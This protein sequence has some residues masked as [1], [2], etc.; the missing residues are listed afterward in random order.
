MRIGKVIITVLVLLSFS[1]LGLA[2]TNQE[3]LELLEEKFLKGE[4]SETNYDRLRKKYEGADTT[5][6]EVTSALPSTS[7]ILSEGFEGGVSREGIPKGWARYYQ[8]GV[9][10]DNK[11]CYR[12]K[13]SLKLDPAGGK[14]GGIQRNV[15]IE[16]GK[17]Y[18]LRVWCY[19]EGK[20][21][22]MMA[23][24]CPGLGWGDKGLDI[25]IS[26]G[27][28]KEF[29]RIV[30]VPVGV[31]KAAL[32]FA[33]WNS[34][35][36]LWV[37]DISVTAVGGE[38]APAKPPT[39]KAPVIVSLQNGEFEDGLSGWKE[40]N[41]EGKINRTTDKQ[42]KKSG[43]ASCK[44]EALEG[45]AY[46]GIRQYVEVQ[47]GRY[48]FSVW[49]KM[50]GIESERNSIDS[51]TALVATNKRNFISMG[52]VK[53]DRD[54]KQFK[55]IIEVPAGVNQVRIELWFFHASGTVW[56]DDVSFVSLDNPV[57]QPKK[58]T[59]TFWLKDD[60]KSSRLSPVLRWEASSE[61]GSSYSLIETPGFLTLVAPANAGMWGKNLKAPRVSCQISA[62][63][64]PTI[65]TKLTNYRPTGNWQEA[66]LFIMFDEKN[67][68]KLMKYNDGS[69]EKIQCAGYT[70]GKAKE[71]PARSHSEPDIWLRIQKDKNTY[72]FQY[73]GDGQNYLTLGRLPLATVGSYTSPSAGLFAANGPN[74][75]K[76]DFLNVEKSS[77]EIEQKGEKEFV[78]KPGLKNIVI[79]DDVTKF[80]FE[81][82]E[83]VELKKELSRDVLQPNGKPSLHVRI[84]TPPGGEVSVN[85]SP[86]AGA[87]EVPC[88]S[89]L[90][91]WCMGKKWP[92]KRAYYTDYYGNSYCPNWRGVTPQW[93]KHTIPLTIPED[94]S[95]AKPPLTL[96]R[97][98]LKCKGGTE[99]DFYLGD[100]TVE[101][102]GIF[103]THFGYDFDCITPDLKSSPLF[104][105]LDWIFPNKDY[106]KH[107][108]LVLELPEGVTLTSYT[109]HSWH[110]ITSRCPL[111]TEKITIEGK[112]YTRNTVNYNV[113]RQIISHHNHQGVKRVH[114]Y[115]TTQL[116]EGEIDAYYYMYFP[117]HEEKP[118]KLTLKVIRIKAV[119]QP[120]L[121]LTE[122][123]I[124]TDWP[125]VL[126][127]VR[128]LGITNV[129]P[130]HHETPAFLQE[131]KTN[132]IPV[133][134]SIME[135][136]IV[137]TL[138]S[139]GA[140]GLKELDGTISKRLACLSRA[141]ES[142]GM[143]RLIDMNKPLVKKGLSLFWFDDEHD[144][145]IQCFCNECLQGFAKF[146]Q[147]H[148]RNLPSTSPLKFCQTVQEHHG[149]IGL[150]KTTLA[151]YD[152]WLDF[153]YANYS[154]TA[155]MLKKGLQEYANQQELE[156]K[157]E[158][159]DCWNQ[160]YRDKLTASIAAKEAFD[161]LGY[162]Y[163]YYAGSPRECG[164]V[165]EKHRN[166]VEGSGARLYWTLGPG[167][168]YWCLEDFHPHTIMKWQTLETFAVG[169]DGVRMWA[170]NDFDLLDM[171]YYSEAIWMV[172]PVEDI[173]VKGQRY[174]D[175]RVIGG[176]AYIR[177][178][179][180]NDEYLV[181]AA[182]YD[183]TDQREVVVQVPDAVNGSEVYDLD[184]RKKLGSLVSNTFKV[185]LTPEE[186]A[187][188]FYVGK[189]GHQRMLEAG[190]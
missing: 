189:Q 63:D 83:N 130:R 92:W 147:K 106:P 79:C 121:L 134:N 11:R 53:G 95:L 67:W 137:D 64:S 7:A 1:S 154:K 167:L 116:T 160:S 59:K 70:Q 97:F 88:S 110:D 150:D 29:K 58:V 45:M 181:L 102:D 171:K 9:S 82:P 178:L 4:I 129:D 127:N 177:S 19:S 176:N 12:G 87:P 155:G 50:L 151:L 65:T 187:K 174:A 86:P 101:L 34:P 141:S 47:P 18:L 23:L 139:C 13:S 84:K 122:M 26:P 91:W 20:A 75:A 85:I 36:P 104:F 98:W 46:G 165:V 159:F 100:L 113:D 52:V 71:Y 125:G 35:N 21:I 76:F 146:R 109:M 182:E 57:P 66:G 186:R 153:H 56:F 24:E 162:A 68:F 49:C 124:R 25:S 51:I 32:R 15:D 119:P 170:F 145:Q 169:V 112:P 54:W 173:V 126:E 27:K 158:F 172:L 14:K 143:Q 94:S 190:D 120:K 16:P 38:A 40:Y 136:H 10:V 148:G 8:T 123:E 60:F 131:C 115:L 30:T 133:E 43:E 90:V 168:C 77:G 183:H 185:K 108:D 161:Y 33:Q 164:D 166:M 73:S 156:H 22:G 2:L 48:L 28:W 31:S 69:E 44:M 188:M 179:K 163:Y 107:V 17:T 81:V 93:T 74:T 184:T 99:Y 96:D 72:I 78:W 140:P 118:K 149:K 111:K 135:G 175:A 152:L 180:L 6:P 55:Q 117:G 80:R 41:R 103:F 39:P 42:V 144:E 61:A 89:R 142:K 3:K 37:D 128:H 138:V 105:G 5:T 114:F 132:G 157:I 62:E